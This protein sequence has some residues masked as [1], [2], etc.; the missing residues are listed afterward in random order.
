[1]AAAQVYSVV[2]LGTE[3]T[4]TECLRE[5]P[6]NSIHKCLYHYSL[7][8]LPSMSLLHQP[9]NSLSMFIEQFKVGDPIPREKWS[10]HLPVELPHFT[11]VKKASKQ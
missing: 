8:I 2:L 5:T 9:Y 3:G 7:V 11:Y 6:N 10:G 4:A 1:M